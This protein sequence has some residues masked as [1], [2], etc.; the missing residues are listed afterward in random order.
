MNISPFVRRIIIAIIVCAIVVF[1]IGKIVAAFLPGLFTAAQ[2]NLI[3]IC[4]WI[5]GLLYVVFGDSWFV[6]KS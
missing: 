6:V 2:L 1:L 4:V 3:D 5:L